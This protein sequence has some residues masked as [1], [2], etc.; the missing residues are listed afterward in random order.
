MRIRLGNHVQTLNLERDFELHTSDQTVIIEERRIRPNVRRM[1]E[2]SDGDLEI[3]PMFMYSS[4]DTPDM[5]V[6]DTDKFDYLQKKII[7]NFLIAIMM[8]GYEITI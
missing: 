1:I 5:L 6:T 8:L 3:K 2:M 4:S 7:T